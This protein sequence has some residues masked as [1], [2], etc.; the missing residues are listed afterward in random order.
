MGGPFYG[1][2][3]CSDIDNA[4]PVFW[5]ET[6]PC[7]LYFLSVA[8]EHSSGA[9]DAQLPGD[10]SRAGDVVTVLDGREAWREP[11]R[12]LWEAGERRRAWIT[13]M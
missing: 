13:G 12:G 5:D 1:W 8:C 2:R 6:G 11:D 10:D 7:G 9:R 3:G 4:P